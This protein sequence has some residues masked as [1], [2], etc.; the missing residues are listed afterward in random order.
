MRERPELARQ[1]RHCAGQK[2]GLCPCPVFA[3][4]S[5]GDAQPESDIVETAKLREVGAQLGNLLLTL[6]GFDF[7]G[8]QRWQLRN[9][10]ACGA[11]KKRT[12]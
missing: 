6:L 9:W 12:K 1:A 4:V 2:A 11:R 10:R 7:S 8:R 5:V 3:G